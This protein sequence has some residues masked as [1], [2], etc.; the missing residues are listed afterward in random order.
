MRIHSYLTFNGNCRAAMEFYKDC[1]GGRLHFQTVGESPLG[2]KM[3]MA[4]QDYI[5]Q[6]TLT[7]GDFLLMASDFVEDKGLIRGNAVSLVLDCDS[8]AD[9]KK[10]YDR[11][12]RGG[13]ATHHLDN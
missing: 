5:L 8:R 3:P 2:E 9:L 13:E 7:K 10:Y 6:S 11:L 12:A 4:M 1:L